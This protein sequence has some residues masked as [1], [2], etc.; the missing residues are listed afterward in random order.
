MRLLWQ[1]GWQTHRGKFYTVEQA[2][3]FT[4][5][6]QPPPIMIAASKP[7]SAELAG[8]IADGLISTVPERELV[9][10]FERGGGKDKPC[11]GQVTV[12]FASSEDDA[13]RIVRQQWP[14]A[15][16]DAPLTTDLPLPKHFEKVAESMQPEKITE[17][18]IL[19]PEPRRHIDAIKKFVR[20]RLRS[21]LRA[22]DRPKAERVPALLRRQSSAA[23]QPRR[24][25]VQRIK[26]KNPPQPSSFR[27]IPCMT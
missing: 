25:I 23:L 17:D 19:G 8:H 16:I 22:S 20:C 27:R 12:C 9:K 3:I 24:E 11:Y 14:N 1:G 21:R 5:P 6:D 13:A 7:R 26:T 2:R 18:V 15:G 10:H 4:M